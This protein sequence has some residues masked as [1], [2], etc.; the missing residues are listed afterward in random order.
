MVELGIQDWLCLTPELNSQ[1]PRPY[2]LWPSFS[3]SLGL[4]GHWILPILLAQCQTTCLYMWPHP[5][6]LIP[7]S[8]PS[9]LSYHRSWTWL[10]PL[11]TGIIWLLLCSRVWCLNWDDS[12]T[13][14]WLLRA[15]HMILAFSQHGSL[16]AADF[17]HGTS[18][19]QK[20]EFQGKCLSFHVLATE[21]R[22]SLSP[23]SIG[24]SS[25]QL[26]RDTNRGYL[27]PT[28]L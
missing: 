28:S 9:P 5:F 12:Q 17:L 25:C 18:G 21:F 22:A 3:P 1:T 19:L 26:T 8:H 16:K 2:S 4:R 24:W 10:K 7:Q 13:R 11:W 23:Y 14:L 6:P 15:L 20:L 27:Y